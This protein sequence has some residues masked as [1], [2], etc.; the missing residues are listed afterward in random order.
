MADKNIIE[1]KKVVKRFGDLT[2]LD[3]IDLN[4]KEGEVFGLL[5]P[6]GAGKTT[7]LNVILGLLKQTSGTI[8]INGL[9]N[10]EHINK[11]KQ[12]IGL[13]TQETVVENELSARQNL[14]LFAELYQVDPAIEKKRVKEALIEAD[15]LNFAD[16]KAG[17]FSGG[18]KRRLELVKSMIHEPPI[19]ILD[20][21]TTGLDV[22]NR[23]QLWV[24]IGDLNK[25]G[26]TIILTT[27]YLEEAD[28][29]CERIA[30][31]D[32]GK[33]KAIG[34]ASELKA[35]VSTGNVLEIVAKWDDINGIVKLLKKYGVEPIVKGDRITASLGSN[36]S[37]LFRKITNSIDDE[38][39]SVL[40]ISTHLPT[41]DD[42]FI[43]LTG[44]QIRDSTSEDAATANKN[45]MWRR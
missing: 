15:L 40:A 10:M 34:T 7:L 16:K 3:G 29:L 23:N 35:M 14:E 8:Y 5:G 17:T 28:A 44:S 4:I 31:I 25:K 22:Q 26:I 43:M 45:K 12:S 36:S 39:I 41:L 6:N 27:Q 2:A 19:L 32:H 18:M 24:K 30:I 9:N 38:K 21:P 33:I 13:M 20:E 42:A 37:K 1:I 11:I